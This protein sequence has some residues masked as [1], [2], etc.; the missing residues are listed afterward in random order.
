MK[1]QLCC[2]L[3]SLVGQWLV[4]L[5]AGV[6]SVISNGDSRSACLLRR[7][8]EAA[9]YWSRYRTS[10]IQVVSILLTNTNNCNKGLSVTPGSLIG[11]TAQIANRQS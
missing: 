5:Q 2:R 4:G 9:S 10:G 8:R 7:E 11:G 1:I 3:D 6:Y